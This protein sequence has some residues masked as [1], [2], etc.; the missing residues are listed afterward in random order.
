MSGKAPEKKAKKKSGAHAP[1][2]YQLP[3]GVWRFGRSEMYARR[4]NYK[5]TITVSEPKK[6]KRIHYKLKPVGG[7]KNGGNRLIHLRKTVC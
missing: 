3:G 5:K 2:N 1:R 7:D 6:R 4:R